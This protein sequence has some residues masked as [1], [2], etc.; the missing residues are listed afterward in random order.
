MNNQKPVIGITAFKNVESPQPGFGVARCLK[1]EGYTII[2]IDDTPLTSAIF[3]PYIDS[4]YL[5]KSMGEENIDEF[6]LD[7]NKII[8]ETKMK[9]LIPCYDREVYFFNKYKLKIEELGVKILIP[10]GESLKMAA[11][12]FLSNLGEI[13]IN[14]PRTI[15]VFSEEGIEKAC[16]E[17]NFPLVCKGIIKD[18]Y[19]ANNIP[20]AKS[21]FQKIREIWHGGKGSVLFQQFVLGETITISGVANKENKV[22]G[23]VIMKKLGIDSKG[24]TWSGM[25]IYSEEVDNLCDKIIKHLRWIGPF[26]LEFI[27]DINSG[28]FFLFEINPRLPSWIYLSKIAGCNIPSL[29][30]DLI[31]GKVIKEKL[32][33]NKEII[34]SR[35]SE[36]IFYTKKEFDDFKKSGKRLFPV[37]G[38][39]GKKND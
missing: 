30:V 38:I 31:N 8:N 19:I 22:V 29:I 34:F 32:D 27:K 7:L 25:T 2:G 33:F 4:V 20:E 37:F 9:I 1:E 6:I 17:I 23:R 18:A 16:E 15:R 3:A 28:K 36:E 21:F 11:K 35:Y 10:S 5:V 13:G 24:T 14:V 39:G 26:E 12:P